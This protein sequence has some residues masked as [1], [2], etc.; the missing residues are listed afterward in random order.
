VKFPIVWQHRDFTPWNVLRNSGGHLS[1]LDWE[2]ARPGPALFDLL[3]FVSHWDEMEADAVTPEERLRAFVRGAP[4]S[5]REIARYCERLGIDP[6][7]VPLLMVYT[8][9]EIALRSPSRTFDA[10]Y[11]GALSDRGPD[12]FRD[13][14]RHAG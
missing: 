2:G 7:F 12:L 9:V 6:R 5:R 14:L 11:V 1:V 13:E 4:A 10:R 3:H 8:R